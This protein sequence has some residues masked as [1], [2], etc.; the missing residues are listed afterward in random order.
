M[1]AAQEDAGRRYRES[2]DK[3]SRLI[4][5][6]KLTNPIPGTEAS[7][8]VKLARKIPHKKRVKKRLAGLHQVFIPGAYV[9]KSSLTTTKINEAG[10]SPV[11]VRD[12]DIA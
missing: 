9:T 3:D 7:L 5:H 11:K 1:C 6:P 2:T 10:R 12:I 8:K 4:I